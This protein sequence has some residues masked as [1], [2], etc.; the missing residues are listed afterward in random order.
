MTTKK[1]A[2]ETTQ[3]IETNETADLLSTYRR[4]LRGKT[5]FYTMETITVANDKVIK[6]ESSLENFP[7]IIMSKLARAAIED[8][9]E[10]YDA[11]SQIKE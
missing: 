4:V 7:A 9:Q 6:S 10:Y 8:A 1:Q 5:G 11:N 2:N 3:A